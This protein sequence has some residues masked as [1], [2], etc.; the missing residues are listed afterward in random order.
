M[1]NCGKKS[2]LCYLEC[3]ATAHRH[4]LALT[5]DPESLCLDL[6]HTSQLERFTVLMYSKS[7]DAATVNEACLKLFYHGL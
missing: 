6:E 1:L 3:H 5:A 7:C 2:G 4:L